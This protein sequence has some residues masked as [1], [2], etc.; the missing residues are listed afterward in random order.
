MATA[1]GRS[2]WVDRVRSVLARYDDDRSLRAAV[3]EEIRRRVRFDAH[4]WLLTDPESEVGS[5]PMAEVPFVDELRR[6]LP[7]LIRAKYLT[8]VNR[9]TALDDTVATLV[10]STGGE[11]RRSLVWRDVLDGLGVVDVASV[12]FRDGHGCWGWLDLWRRFLPPFSEVEH[13]DLIAVAAPVTRALRRCQAGTFEQ[14]LPDRHGGGPVVLILSPALEVRAQTPETDAYLR[15]LVP[16]E[17]DDRP[18][19]AAAYNVAAQLL[20]IEAGVDEHPPWARVNIGS[21]LWMT[22]RAGRVG[23]SEPRADQDIAVTIE[24]STPSERLGLFTRSHGLTTREAELVRLLTNGAD[25]RTVAQVLHLS[26]HT[27]QDHLKSIFD[28]TRT[29]NRRTLISRISGC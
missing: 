25:T 28:K 21:S 19:P 6:E 20:A 12:V 16:P 23:G 9:W 5:A 7:T 1:A 17:G 24:R 18:I 10:T 15:A 11:C 14:E 27:V 29:R 3:L 22:L 26:E 2:A 13:H 4:A 8:P